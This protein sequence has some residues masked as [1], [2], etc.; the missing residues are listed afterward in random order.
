MLECD[1][2]LSLWPNYFFSMTDNRRRIKVLLLVGRIHTIKM[3][4]KVIIRSK[5]PFTS[6]FSPKCLFGTD[7]TPKGE[8]PLWPKWLRD[9][10]QIYSTWVQTPAGL[11]Q[12]VVSS[13]TS[14]HYLWR[15]L[16]QFSLTTMCTKVAVKQH[17]LDVNP[18]EYIL[19]TMLTH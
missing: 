8:A 16:G 6:S 12:K 10:P 1:R 17:H 4:N 15:S 9:W 18:K 14:P 11:C 5:M 19:N 13:F 7:L 3:V 2:P